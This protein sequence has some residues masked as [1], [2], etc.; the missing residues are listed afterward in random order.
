[1]D[2]AERQRIVEENRLEY[3]EAYGSMRWT[4]PEES[5]RA[6]AERAALLDDLEGRVSWGCGNAKADC[7][8]LSGGC[9][10][11]AERSWS[12]LFVNGVCNARCF[13]CPSEQREVGEPTTN[14]L[15]FARPEHYAAY[16]KRF[17]FRGSS[18]SGGE[19]LLSFDRT[20]R[21]L[22]AA[23]RALGSEGWLWMYTNGILLTREKL[24]RLGETGLDEIR[25]DLSANGY[26]LGALRLASEH[27]GTVTVEIP[28]IPEDEERVRGLLPELARSGVKHLNLHELRCTPYNLG[29]LL[30]RGAVFRHGARVTVVGSE[31]AAL[32]L[33]SAS[34][35]APASPA[36]NYC[37]F[38]YKH[39]YQGSAARRRAAEAWLEGW[40][41]VSDAGYVRRSAA[42]GTGAELDAA[43][44]RLLSSGADPKLWR[45]DRGA[46]RLELH[47]SL[48]AHAAGLALTVSYERS[49]LRPSVSYRHPFRE[50]EL[51]DGPAVF[52]ERETALAEQSLASGGLAALP[53]GIRERYEELGE[54]LDPYF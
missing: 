32:R 11:C 53:R 2:A 27:V 22:T 47:P 20:I 37:S 24:E 39:R 35:D 28:A 4:T 33:L 10:A 50:L 21:Y 52:V 29:R 13:Y 14:T 16:L 25:L 34:L 17:G 40:E 54:G 44:T 26:E 30:G 41:S 48:L 38:I 51:G 8:T 18:M 45:M 6:E 49:T 9:R 42:R 7:R 36:V 5:S 1:M 43:L 19:P 3:G 12:C 46:G 15:P 31:L 23:R